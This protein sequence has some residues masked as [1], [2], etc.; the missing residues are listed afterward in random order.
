[1]QN[2]IESAQYGQNEDVVSRRFLESIKSHARASK[3]QEGTAHPIQ[4]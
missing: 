3:L 4:A 1:M 2:K